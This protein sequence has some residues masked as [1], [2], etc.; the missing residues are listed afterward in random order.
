M[1]AKVNPAKCDCGGTMT[2]RRVSKTITLAGRKVRVENVE[3]FVC[4][5]CGETYIDGPTL[6]KL[7]A[8]LLKTPLPA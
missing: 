2:L 6:L 4:A 3:A 8:K 5:K 1:K 7:E